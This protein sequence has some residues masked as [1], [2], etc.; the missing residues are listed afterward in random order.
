MNP[1]RIP[2]VLF[3]ALVTALIFLGASSTLTADHTGDPSS[4]VIA[5]SLQDELGC[6]GDWQPGAG[7]ERPF[8]EAGRCAAWVR[9]RWLSAH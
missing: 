3:S 7:P 2:F 9:Q 5:G 8:N 1:N 4:V 6:P